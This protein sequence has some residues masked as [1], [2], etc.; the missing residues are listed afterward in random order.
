MYDFQKLSQNCL[1]IGETIVPR[2]NFEMNGKVQHKISQSVKSE[3]CK[4]YGLTLSN[5]DVSDSQL[6]AGMG[7]K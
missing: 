1:G 3:I 5:F 2:I 4:H 6:N 7:S